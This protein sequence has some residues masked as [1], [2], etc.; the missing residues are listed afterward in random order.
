MALQCFVDAFNVL[1]SGVSGQTI[2]RTGYGFQPKCCLYWWSGRMETTDISVTSGDVKPGVGVACSATDRRCITAQMDDLAGTMACDGRQSDAACIETLTL[3]G[4]L[5]GSVDLQ[6]FDSDG[7]TLVIDNPFGLSQTHRIHCLAIGGSDL[8]NA[9]T[10]QFQVPTTPGNA[11]VTGLSF[12]PTA[13]ILFSAGIAT[14]PPAGAIHSRYSL[15]FAT[16]SGAQGVCAAM[17]TD[18][19]NSDVSGRYS[20]SSECM[21]VMDTASTITARASFVAFLSTGFTLNWLEVSGTQYYVFGLALR[22]GQFLAGNFAQS[23]TLNG[24]VVETGVGFTP[25]GLLVASVFTTESA[26]DVQSA[27]YQWNV[28]AATSPSNRASQGVASRNGAASAICLSGSRG[29]SLLVGSNIAAGTADGQVDMQALGSDGFTAIM[30][31]AALGQ[32]L[33]LYLA[34]GSSVGTPAAKSLPPARRPWRYFRGRR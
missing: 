19:T 25:T 31:V 18:A 13:V 10:F 16:G 27:Q 34:M 3:T 6:S 20:R 22:G 21:A 7:Q 23:T 17:D 30:D 12:Q 9:A 5:D 29:D 28:G 8:A 4:S 15:G 32:H 11:D 24:S 33:T 2:V 1:A 26:A 14:A